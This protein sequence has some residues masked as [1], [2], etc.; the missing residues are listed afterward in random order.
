MINFYNAEA[1]VLLEQGASVEQIDNAATK[2]GMK[3]G[4]LAMG[5]LV[6]LDLGIQAKKKLNLYLPDKFIQDALIDA[7]RLGL[8][9]GKGFWDY[10]EKRQKKP[11]P[12]VAQLA[13]KVA[14]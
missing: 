11:A 10:D 14:Q 1:R 4:P 8:K 12:I 13:E 2:F 3:M 6:G 9:N 5:D 7:G